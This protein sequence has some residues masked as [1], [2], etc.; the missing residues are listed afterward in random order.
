MYLEMELLLLHGLFPSCWWVL[1]REGR[2]GGS[3]CCLKGTFGISAGLGS[4]SE[5][6]PCCE[7]SHL[8]LS[9]ALLCSQRFYYCS[10]WCFV[11]SRQE[12]CRVTLLQ[13]RWEC[14]WLRVPCNCFWWQYIK[15]SQRK[16]ELPGCW[17]WGFVE[18]LPSLEESFTL[19]TFLSL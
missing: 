10:S 19:K 12:T 18:P 4:I 6:F 13:G 9:K 2:A 14:R 17:A 15:N 3:C 8:L 5:L 11:S 7:S 1:G 16:E